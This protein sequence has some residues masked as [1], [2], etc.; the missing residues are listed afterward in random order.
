MLF[1][2]QHLGRDEHIYISS[3][4]TKMKAVNARTAAI[5]CRLCHLRCRY[6]LPLESYLRV[7]LS[8]SL[9][10]VSR[11]T[12]SRG[13]MRRLDM[14]LASQSGFVWKRN[15]HSD[16]AQR[17]HSRGRSSVPRW[18]YNNGGGRTVNPEVHLMTF[19]ALREEGRAQK[20][21]IIAFR[22][23][24]GICRMV[25][26]TP[27]NLEP[28]WEHLEPKPVTICCKTTLMSAGQPSHIIYQ[29]ERVPLFCRGCVMMPPQSYLYCFYRI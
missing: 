15:C 11:Q 3:D 6:R 20:C 2:V 5:L 14:G 23:G 22:R 12:A 13:P 10:L 29:M 28:V 17:F 21:S 8:I 7:K 25:L 1:N 24:W 27:L 4:W 26:V 19:L 9:A 16:V 18:H